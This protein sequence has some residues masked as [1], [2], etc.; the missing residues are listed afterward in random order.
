MWHE[1]LHGIFP[2]TCSHVPPPKDTSDFVGFA[3]LTELLHVIWSEGTYRLAINSHKACSSARGW[4]E[5][6]TSAP[7][8]VIRLLCLV[9]SQ[10]ISFYARV[11]PVADSSLDDNRHCPFLAY[12]P[13]FEKIKLGICDLHAVCVFPAPMS[14]WMAKPMFMKLGVWAISAAYFINPS[15]QSV[16]L[17]VCPSYCD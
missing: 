2:Q 10:L 13:Y 11:R 15:H 16:C 12:F 1:F 8:L 9:R 6:R 4:R 5:G 3:L 7:G 17:Y 14:F